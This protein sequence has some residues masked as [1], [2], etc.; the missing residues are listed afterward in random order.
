MQ[1]IV[2]LNGQYVLTVAEVM[3][4]LGIPATATLIAVDLNESVQPPTVTFTA[5]QQQS[6][7]GTP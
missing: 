5:V 4:A 7:T 1:T 3:S 2:T 6:N